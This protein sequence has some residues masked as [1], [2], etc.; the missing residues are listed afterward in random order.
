M[1]MMASMK[2]VWA[3]V[4]IVGALMLASKVALADAVAKAPVMVDGAAVSAIGNVGAGQV[5]HVDA[6]DIR[7]PEVVDPDIRDV[8]VEVRV[9]E[10]E[11]PD[12]QVPEVEA[13]DVHVPEVSVPDVHLPEINIPESH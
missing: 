6:A 3:T 8:E 13:P 7:A 9:P 2:P 10:V 5:E 4:I 1:R 12:V 11:A